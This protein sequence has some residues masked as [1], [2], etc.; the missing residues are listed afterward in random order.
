[1]MTPLLF[2]CLGGLDCECTTLETVVTKSD[3]GQSFPA[4]FFSEAM[5]AV[6]I[7]VLMDKQ[8]SSERKNTVSSEVIKGITYRR[9]KG[10]EVAI[11][12][13]KGANPPVPTKR[14]GPRSKW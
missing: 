7:E 10:L 11:Q 13:W 14:T 12:P 4:H 5:A 2:T 6:G 8:N 1:M 3:H 9:V